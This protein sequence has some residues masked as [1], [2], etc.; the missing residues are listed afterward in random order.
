MK[1]NHKFKKMGIIAGMAVAVLT[2]GLFIADIDDYEEISAGIQNDPTAGN[3]I[4]TTEDKTK[5]SNYYYRTKGFTITDS[6]TG[7]SIRISLDNTDDCTY[8]QTEKMDGSG[9]HK[10]Q[11]TIGYG[12]IMQKIQQQYPDWAARIANNTAAAIRFDGIITVFK[13]G[14]QSGIIAG[15]GSTL[16]GTLYDKDNWEQLVKDYPE[17]AHLNKDIMNHYDKLLDV[18]NGTWIDADG[19]GIYDT[20]IPKTDG[21]PKPSPSGSPEPTPTPP[22]SENEEYV[23]TI[24]DIYKT[25]YATYN[26]D[27]T[28][29]FVIGANYRYGSNGTGGIPSDEDITNGYEAWKWYGG[30]DVCRRTNAEHSWTFKGDVEMTVHLGTYHKVYYDEEDHSKGYYEEEDTYSYTISKEHTNGVVTRN[31]RY[32]YLGS[33]VV[34][35][36]GGSWFYGLNQAITENEVFPDGSYQYYYTK[37]VDLNVTCNGVD[38]SAVSSYSMTPDDDWHV[39][40][41]GAV[42][43]P[44]ED[45]IVEGATA[46]CSVG[47]GNSTRW[48][49]ASGAVASIAESHIKPNGEIEVRNDE[50]TIE[51]H[52]YMSSDWYQFRDFHA[53]FGETNTATEIA[54]GDHAVVGTVGEDIGEEKTGRIPPETANDDYPTQITTIYKKIVLATGQTVKNGPANN[55]KDG[56]DKFGHHYRNDNEAIRVH[57]PTVS[58]VEVINPTTGEKYDVNDMPNQ[59]VTGALNTDADYQFL[60]DG[61]YTIKFVPETHFE[62]MGYD[63]PEYVASMYNKYCAFREV[64]FPFTV[65]VNGKIYEPTD[66]E[67]SESDHRKKVKGYTDWIRLP[68]GDD[69]K[70]EVQVDF[71]IPTWAVEGSNYICQFRVAPINV[72]DHR[73]TDHIE[74]YDGKVTDSAGIEVWD[75]DW[76]RLKNIADEHGGYTLYDYVSTYTFSCQVSGIIYNF[77]AVGINDKDRFEGYKKQSNGYD[78]T[79]GLGMANYF[80]FCPTKQEK[81]S[82]TNNRFGNSAVRY[83]IDG[84]LTNSW[85]EANTLPF[86]IGRSQKYKA[87]GDLVRGNVFAFT[88]RTIANLGDEDALMDNSTTGDCLI[89]KPTFRYISNNGTVTEDIDVYCDTENTDGTERLLF[90]K[91][92]SDTDIQTK[93]E[94]SISD[95]RFNGSYYYNTSLYEPELRK[96]IT[97][98]MMNPLLP[99]YAIENEILW[100]YHADDA[101]Y[102]AEKASEY[103]KAKAN[104]EGNMDFPDNVYSTDAYLN[105]KTNSYCLSEIVLNS[106][107]RLLTGNVEQLKMNENNAGDSLEYLDDKLEDGTSYKVTPQ[108]CETYDKDYWDKHRKSMQTWFGTYWIPNQLYIT[109]DKFEADADGDGVKETYD[110]IRDYAEAKGYIEQDDPVFKKTGYLVVNFQI[111]TRNNGED[112]LVY[113]GSNADMWGIEG[114][115]STVEVGDD[116]TTKKP[117]ITVDVRHG[118]VA[119]IDL[120]RS[121]MDRWTTGYNRIN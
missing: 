99:D 116:N 10:A 6:E 68:D 101:E 117:K 13:N 110:N 102:S 35:G 104:A 71:Y 52:T 79:N 70:P 41:E 91:A 77:Q 56:N 93:R 32:W 63:D 9:R 72:V 115:P 106:R 31:T 107:L 50:C 21:S 105:K 58:P 85:N 47:D 94:V 74:S 108:T 82:G 20:F 45:F 4:F 53:N 16:A 112:H 80:P 22:W 54:D 96:I 114:Q 1:F 118:D 14:S 37:P 67:Y 27:P 3:V 76:N 65:Q 15:D 43:D 60:L 2:C 24:G 36:I 120:D 23:K 83:T 75:Y 66:A 55:I 40:W 69:G 103:Q 111:Y 119:I 61:T 12:T 42:K 48:A 39:N 90:V 18:M 38:L 89:I 109:D 26:Y 17:L 92:G 97:K 19:D 113:Q 49:I 25:Y 86:S 30:A 73:T 98:D 44:G 62:H 29:K 78:V 88:V 64:C 95:I 34:R 8:K 46:S 87:E 5:T 28:G 81:K 7:Q 121:V 84:N 57:T 51:G 59:L 33:D 100:K 11:W